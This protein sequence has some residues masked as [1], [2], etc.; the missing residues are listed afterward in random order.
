M[1]DTKERAISPSS[2]VAN[3][4]LIRSLCGPRD[5]TP[6]GPVSVWSDSAPA[7]SLSHASPEAAKCSGVPSPSLA[8]DP[9]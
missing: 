7:I 1:A 5:S 2:S 3:K 6:L 4:R 8:N 9:I